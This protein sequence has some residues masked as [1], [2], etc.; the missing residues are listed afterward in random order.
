MRHGKL[1]YEYLQQ[2]LPLSVLESAQGFYIGTFDE[3]GPCSRES[4]EYYPTAQAAKAALDDNSF[5]QRF[6]P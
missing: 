2:R 3:S 5:S 4:E 6:E 1:A